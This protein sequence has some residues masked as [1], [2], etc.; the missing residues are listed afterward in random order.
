MQFPSH[1]KAQKNSQLSTGDPS[2]AT[3]SSAEVAYHAQT[4]LNQQ[5][6][7]STTSSGASRGQLL[8]NLSRR[9]FCLVS[10][11]TLLV[12]AGC[13]PPADNSAD[14]GE[15]ELH[16][17][18]IPKGTTHIFWQSVKHG[19]EQAGEEIGAKITFRGPSKENDRDEQ[20]NV[21]QGFLNARVDGILLA[22]LDADALVRPVKEASRA[23]VPVVIFDSGLNTDPGDF[24]SYVATDNFEGGKLAGEAMANALGEKGGDVILLRY[25]QGSESTHQ[26]EEGFLYSI[27]E[28]SNIRVLSSDQYAGTTTESAID[29]AQ[30]L[31]NRFGDEVDGICTVCE[32]TAEGALRALRER[33]LA[34]KVKLVTFDS[35]DSLRESLSAGEVNA[36]VL[37]DPVAM[38]YQAVKTM[39][40]HLRGETPEQFIDTGVFV[41]TAKNQ[42]DENIARLL[43]PAVS[44]E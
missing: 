28:Y 26:R 17:A 12:C 9:S 35:S 39:A 44:G 23:G 34:G 15:K 43:R 42:D 13:Q 20:I 38:G 29:K 8:A 21:V 3:T 6:V 14:A 27:A 32:P 33:K 31:L 7:I 36:I 25:E 1:P 10:V 18:V 22:P 4:P 40:A 30:A 41:A 5:G 2:F 19:A 16:F 24:V 37:Q 11:A